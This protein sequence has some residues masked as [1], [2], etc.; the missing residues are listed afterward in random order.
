MRLLV[1]S[2]LDQGSTIKA[3][4]WRMK[5]ELARQG[6]QGV[7]RVLEEQLLECV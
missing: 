3:A 4:C 6:G 2:L 7:V 5:W 1:M